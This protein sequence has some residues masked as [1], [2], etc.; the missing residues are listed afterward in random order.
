VH[1][2]TLFILLLPL[3][4]LFLAL[5]WSCGGGG[6]STRQEQPD[7][8]NCSAT[9]PFSV[10]YRT[11]AKHVDL[12]ADTPIE[13]TV[14]DILNFPLFQPQPASDAPRAGRENNLYHVA[15]A[16]VQFVRLIDSDCDVHVEIS[17][18]ADKNAPRV[19][20]ETPHMDSYCLARHNLSAQLNAHGLTVDDAGQDVD[21]ALPA[22]V[23]G[24][25]F[26]DNPHSRGTAQVGTLW[27]LHPAV[28]TLK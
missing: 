8:C 18:S 26:Q 17:A 21:P 4:V 25:A 13:I 11:V 1:R 6:I 10:D 3:G 24:L 14:T 28:V 2:K 16:F 20:V 22:E 27:E 19:I 23:L 12:P 7:L 5:A 15:N 9:E